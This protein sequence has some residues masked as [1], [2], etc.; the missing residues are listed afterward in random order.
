MAMLNL[1]SASVTVRGV[2]PSADTLT[3]I[4]GSP[5]S[6]VTVP[7]SRRLPLS[8]MAVRG[9]FC[10]FVAA[11]CAVAGAI[12]SSEGKR[13]ATARRC[14]NAWCMAVCTRGKIGFI[15][16]WGIVLY[17]YDVLCRLLSYVFG[18]L[19]WWL[20]PVFV[21]RF[22]ND[23]RRVTGVMPICMRGAKKAHCHNIF[24]LIGCK[25]NRFFAFEQEKRGFR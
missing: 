11:A 6:S 5:F 8:G 25:D 17:C 20:M 2:E 24:H 14:L 22:L 13:M 7:R 4:S 19:L 9:A 21:Y 18:G 23:W 3:P 12:A 16:F 1:P 10:G 15:G